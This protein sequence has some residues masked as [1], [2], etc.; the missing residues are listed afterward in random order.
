MTFLK[1]IFIPVLQIHMNSEIFLCCSFLEA[2]IPFT[3]KI[4]YCSRVLV[5]INYLIFTF[6]PFNSKCYNAQNLLTFYI[7]ITTIYMLLLKTS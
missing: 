2:F 3:D 7:T 4:I 6:L 5:Q 1:I